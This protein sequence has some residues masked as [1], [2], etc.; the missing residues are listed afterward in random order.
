MYYTIQNWSC[1][2]CLKYVL[3][4]NLKSPDSKGTP[5]LEY[6]SITVDEKKEESHEMETL[7]GVS[8]NH[9]EQED[10]INL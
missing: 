10:K 1:R 2:Y 9:E 3:F 4:K 7:G 8:G 5:A 6:I